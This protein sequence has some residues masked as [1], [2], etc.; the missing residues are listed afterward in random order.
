M[1]AW[2][3]RLWHFINLAIWSTTASQGEFVALLI[4]CYKVYKMIIL[5]L[6]LKYKRSLEEKP[7]AYAGDRSKENVK[8]SMY[9]V[10]L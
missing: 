2:R 10:V 6:C 3:E 7:V 9:M 5:S 8:R 4:H 1:Q